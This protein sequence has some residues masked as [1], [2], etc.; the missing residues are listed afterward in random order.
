MERAPPFLAKNILNYRLKL[1]HVGL[2]KKEHSLAFSAIIGFQFRLDRFV[3]SPKVC[4]R[5]TG[6]N[7]F[8]LHNA[9]PLTL[10]F[11]QRLQARGDRKA[12]RFQTF[13]FGKLFGR[14]ADLA[15]AFQ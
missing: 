13:A 2:P 4:A 3:S 11:V 12:V 10:P 5:P 9:K 8:A 14:R 7:Q 15:Q 6:N 1:W